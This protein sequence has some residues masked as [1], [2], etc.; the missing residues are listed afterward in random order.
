VAGY[1]PFYYVMLGFIP[2]V[3]VAALWLGGSKFGYG[4]RAIA[5]ND[6]L[7]EAS[8]ST[9]L[10]QAP[11]LRPSAPAV[12]AMTAARRI[13]AVLHQRGRRL[14]RSITFQMVVMALLGGLGTPFG[15]IVG[16]AFLPGLGVPGHALVYH[17]LIAIGDDHRPRL[18]VC[19]PPLDRHPCG[20][21]PSTGATLNLLE[22]RAVTKRSDR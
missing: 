5:E 12:M 11:C 7:A 21:S 18:A 16:A 17:Y 3:T 8:A 15:P 19:L 20:G 14:Q 6:R 1:V 2:A 4:L 13:L 9:S 10:S 22:V